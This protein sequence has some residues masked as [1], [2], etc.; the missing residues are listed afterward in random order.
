MK[1]YTY[2]QAKADIINSPFTVALGWKTKAGNLTKAGEMAAR[3][4]AKKIPMKWF[5]G[6]IYVKGSNAHHLYKAKR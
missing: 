3:G 2:Q 6:T 1:Q 4:T 5:G